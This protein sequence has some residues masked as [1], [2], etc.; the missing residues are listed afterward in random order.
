MLTYPK[1]KDCKHSKSKHGVALVST[2]VGW[3]KRRKTTEVLRCFDCDKFLV[4]GPTYEW[5]FDVVATNVRPHHEYRPDNL[6]YLEHKYE[7]AEQ[8]SRQK[9]QETESQVG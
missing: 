5:E 9:P 2:Y 1:C 8:R 6:G 4:Y 7:K 3:H